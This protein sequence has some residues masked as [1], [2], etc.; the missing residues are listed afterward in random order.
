[1]RDRVEVV[2][3]SEQTRK[4]VV[5]PVVPKVRL[6]LVLDIRS[7]VFLTT[8]RLI[9][10]TFN[11]VEPA[12]KLVLVIIEARVRIRQDNIDKAR[13]QDGEPGHTEDL[14]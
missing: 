4:P 9:T 6:D 2:L 13:H 11:K 3:V 10:N 14:Y 1:M 8:V 5:V 7:D 12:L